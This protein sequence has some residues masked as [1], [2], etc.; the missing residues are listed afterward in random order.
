MRPEN[1]YGA[2]KLRNESETELSIRLRSVVASTFNE[3]ALGF[4]RD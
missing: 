4:G 2:F 3:L 1:F